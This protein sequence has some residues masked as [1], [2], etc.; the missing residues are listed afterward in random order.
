MFGYNR[1]AEETAYLFNGYFKTQYNKGM[2]KERN[3]L[4]Y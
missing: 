4:I 2:S 1:M 3:R